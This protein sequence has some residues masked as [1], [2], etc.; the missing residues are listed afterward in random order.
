MAKNGTVV[1]HTTKQLEALRRR[2]KSRTDWA[3]VDAT[4]ARALKASIAADPDDTHAALDWTRAVR[5][6]PPPKRAIKL[7]ID[8]DVLAWFRATGKGYQTRMN[9][10]L[11]A[12]AKRGK[13]VR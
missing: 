9:N 3:K 12:Y 11:R 5:G 13:S 4:G 2:G 10:V 1:R 8:A 7:R 6:L